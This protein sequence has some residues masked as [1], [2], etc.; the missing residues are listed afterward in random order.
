MLLAKIKG[1]KVHFGKLVSFL[2]EGG[3]NLPPTDPLEVVIGG[4]LLEN[5]PTGGSAQI[6]SLR[7]GVRPP[8]TPLRTSMDKIP[9]EKWGK[10]VPRAAMGYAQQLKSEVIYF[11]DTVR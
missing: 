3:V 1:S 10:V 5:F 4:H 6:L 8:R 11:L 9:E 2:G 7:G